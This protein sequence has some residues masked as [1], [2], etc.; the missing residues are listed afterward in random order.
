M[1][2][3][4]RR[5]ARWRGGVVGLALLVSLLIAAC[6]HPTSEPGLFGRHQPSPTASGSAGRSGRSADGGRLINPDLPVLGERIWFSGEGGAV[7]FRIGLHGLR[8]VPGGTV[9]D[10]SITPLPRVGLEPGEQ[11]P[12]TVGVGP[13]GDPLAFR[14]IDT[15]G[16]RVYGPLTGRNGSDCLCTVPGSRLEVG[17]TLIQQLVFPALPSAVH[18][19]AVDIP[20]VALFTGVPLPDPGQVVR[21]VQPVDLA[22]PPDVDAVSR[23]TPAF[24]YRPTGQR[25][26]IGI[27]SV[28]ASSDATSVVWSVQSLSPG[29]G[30]ER[31]GGPPIT[32]A[33]DA[34]A[35]RSVASGLQLAVS[36]SGRVR[37]GR[38]LA[39][40]R[41]R[42]AGDRSAGRS[43]GACLCTDLRGWTGGMTGAGRSVTV[44]S[45]LPALPLHAERVDVIL[46]GLPRIPRVPVQRPGGAEAGY[47]GFI[48]DHGA[49]W[50]SAAPY[51]VLGWPVDLW[52]TPRPDTSMLQ[53]FD[54]SVGRLR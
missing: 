7:P 21:A 19:V 32:A 22:R 43:D 1:G 28:N 45:D 35:D 44:V 41:D 46:P 24:S 5:R 12:D 3:G 15:G 39:V 11:L 50:S 4:G 6:S 2:V 9:L 30:L 17:Q 29:A 18:A 49:H 51:Q 52:P 20:S 14:L 36:A 10:W 23:W 27:I 31:P 47:G 13:A 37:A 26:R 33:A 53:F 42:I 8:R 34:A 16:D 38:P 54:V 25:F 40:W 48:A